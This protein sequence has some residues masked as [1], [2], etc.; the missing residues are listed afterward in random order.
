MSIETASGGHALGLDQAVALALF[1]AVLIPPYLDKASAT[2]G[3]VTVAMGIAAELATL[4]VRGSW[5]E[6]TASALPR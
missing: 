1:L 2:A 3:S 5:N 4:T 6:V